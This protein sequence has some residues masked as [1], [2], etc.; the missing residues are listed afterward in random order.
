[1]QTLLVCVYRLFCC[2]IFLG[3]YGVILKEAYHTVGVLNAEVS[4][5]RRHCQRQYARRLQN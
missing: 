2:V 1:M 4:P 3:V 5:R